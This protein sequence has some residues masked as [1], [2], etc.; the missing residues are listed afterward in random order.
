MLFPPHT[1]ILETKSPETEARA[2]MNGIHRIRAILLAA[3]FLLL[4]SSPALAGAQ[5]FILVNRTGY[6]IYVVNVSPSGSKEWQEDVLGAKI[7]ADG[8]ALEIK[9][10]RRQERYWDMQVKFKDGSGLYWMRLDLMTTSVI[11]LNKDGTATIK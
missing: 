3:A 8:E 4:S 9:F 5:D 11:A 10:Q 6:D 7:L 2:T 1:L